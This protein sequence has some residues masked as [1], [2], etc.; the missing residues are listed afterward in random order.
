MAKV[1]DVRWGTDKRPVAFLK[2]VMEAFC[3][4]THIEPKKTE[5]SG[6]VP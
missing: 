2:Q 3:H 5:K 4:Y 6:M 1:S